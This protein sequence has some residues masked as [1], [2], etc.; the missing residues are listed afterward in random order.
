VLGEGLEPV[1][2]FSCGHTDAIIYANRKVT[3]RAEGGM[4]F[5]E[6][7]STKITLS[8]RQILSSL[9]NRSI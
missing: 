2:T 8:L 6:K 5:V 9:T 4:S 1:K 3:L 7:A